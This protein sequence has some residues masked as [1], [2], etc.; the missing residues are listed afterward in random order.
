MPGIKP[1]MTDTIISVHSGASGNPDLR[2]GPR[3]RGANGMRCVVLP[4][5]PA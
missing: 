1:G 2:L 5:I 3:L 4:F